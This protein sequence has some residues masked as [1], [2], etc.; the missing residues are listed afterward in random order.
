[1]TMNS[2]TRL[3]SY[4]L[5]FAIVLGGCLSLD[6]ESSMT[7]TGS[8]KAI[9][10]APEWTPFEL[11][12]PWQPE[13]DPGFRPAKVR[14]SWKPAALH[15]RADLTDDEITSNSTGDN[16][17]MWELGDTFEFF[18]MTAGRE[19]YVELH[20]TPNG[21]RLHAHFPSKDRRSPLEKFL[22]S[23]PSFTAT[24]TPTESGWRIEAEIPPSVL[25]AASFAAGSRLRIAFARYDASLTGKPVLSS[26]A[27]HREIAFH[28]PDDWTPIQLVD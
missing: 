1:M 3:I 7:P 6:A 9:P 20:V 13:T 12:Q 24:A 8:E 14:V 4:S 11:G 19:D 26:S 21:H 18:L 22:V 27:R 16:Q 23:P 17:K 5:G 2:P 25:G 28:R 10:Q 15:V